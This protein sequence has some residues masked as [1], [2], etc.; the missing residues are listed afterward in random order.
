MSIA[1]F[2]AMSTNKNAINSRP[3]AFMNLAMC[4]TLQDSR[5]TK[6]HLKKSLGNY[7][8]F[9]SDAICQCE[10]QV[11]LV[12]ERVR[13]RKS[14]LAKALHAQLTVNNYYLLIRWIQEWAWS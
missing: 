7:L 10:I 3:M 8:I 4:V 9:R 1:T 12:L 11:F 2:T 14:A 5:W 6:R 13:K